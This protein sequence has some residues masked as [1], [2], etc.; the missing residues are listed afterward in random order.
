[1]IKLKGW[2]YFHRKRFLTQSRKVF[3]CFIWRHS[4]LC[5]ENLNGKLWVIKRVNSY[6]RESL[7]LW[8]LAALFYTSHI[9]PI[10]HWRWW[11]I[12]CLLNTKWWFVSLLINKLSTF[13]KILVLKDV[14]HLLLISQ[15][16]S[17]SY[18][19]NSFAVF[20][21]YPLLVLITFQFK[22]QIYFFFVAY[23]LFNTSPL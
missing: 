15:H 13:Y 20:Q 16:V 1:M 17:L 4:I 9:Y 6:T 3:F 19:N 14:V 18:I 10:L 7:K 22:Q 5:Y 8:L 2:A 12:K 23:L 11:L 21:K